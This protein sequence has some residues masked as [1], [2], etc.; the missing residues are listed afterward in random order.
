VI[1]LLVNNTSMCALLRAGEHE[2]EK[3]DA[4]QMRKK[5]GV[6]IFLCCFCGRKNRRQRISHDLNLI[7][8]P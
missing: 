6:K 7:R 1:L 3:S 8:G 5:F 4:N 2:L